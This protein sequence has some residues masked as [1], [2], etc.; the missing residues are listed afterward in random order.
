MV[1]SGAAND[2]VAYC[3]IITE[4]PLEKYYVRVFGHYAKNKGRMA[5][6]KSHG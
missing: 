5:A 3:V 2:S 4:K 6:A 1:T